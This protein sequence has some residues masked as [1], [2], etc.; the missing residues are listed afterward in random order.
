[1]IFSAEQTFSWR[2]EITGSVRST[3][4]IDL[5]APGTVI[6]AP[7]PLVRDIGK[8]RGVPILVQI[9]S[10]FTGLDSLTVAVQTAA[11][12]AFETT[13]TVLAATLDAEDL[14][15]GKKFPIVWVPLGA[16]SRYLGLTYLVD[17]AEEGEEEEGPVLGL[18]T[19]GIVAA[20][21]TNDTVPGAEFTF[22]PLPEPDEGEGEGE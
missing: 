6:G 16:A 12:E 11:A 5:K 4:I 14:R 1:M 7:A 2:Q 10:D 8:G 20:V 18:V 15:A 19:A 9:V 22:P 21:Q 13:T 3:N 17:G